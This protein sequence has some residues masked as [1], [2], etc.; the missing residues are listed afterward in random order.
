[1]HSIL[2]LLAGARLPLAGRRASLMGLAI[3]LAAVTGCSSYR[4]RGR[5]IEGRGVPPQ[6]LIVNADDERLQSPGLAFG[7]IEATIDPNSIKPL[8]IPLARTDEHGDFDIPVDKP[9]AGVLDYQLAMVVR[10]PGHRPLV[11]EIK[12]PASFRRLLIV[13]PSGRDNYRP[14]RDPLQDA[15]Q[16]EKEMRR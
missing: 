9:G 1:M 10:A 3:L 16:Y 4:L 12:L 6:V 7:S 13:L 11:E 15:L 5:I 2:S 14:E 8:R